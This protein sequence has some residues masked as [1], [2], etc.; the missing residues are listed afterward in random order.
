[1][2]RPALDEL[3]DNARL[4]RSEGHRRILAMWAGIAAFKAGSANH[5]PFIDEEAD[6]V[7][8]FRE[9][10]KIAGDQLS[11]E[12]PVFD[13]TPCHLRSHGAAVG[14]S[15]AELSAPKEEE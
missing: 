8:G 5:C 12:Q 15:Y 9:G 11:R 1:M 10:V 13:L 2:S 14:R 3:V 7:G 6:L 4:E